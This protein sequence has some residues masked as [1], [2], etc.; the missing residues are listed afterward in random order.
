MNGLPGFM[1]PRQEPTVDTPISRPSPIEAA[2]QL[3][4]TVAQLIAERDHLAEELR[5]TRLHNE[6]LSAQLDR[7]EQER[8]HYQG[9]ANYFERFAMAI[10]TNFNTIRMIVDDTQRKANEF[11][12]SDTPLPSPDAGATSPESRAVDIATRSEEAVAAA[13]ADLQHNGSK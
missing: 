12:R 5:L 2:N 8:N 10:V 7:A 1:K 11:S 13:L 3:G 6:T 9:K 4:A